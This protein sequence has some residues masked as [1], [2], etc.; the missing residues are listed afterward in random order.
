MSA[1]LL[2]VLTFAIAALTAAFAAPASADVP[3]AP[4]NDN[5]A[6]AVTV[7]G[8]STTVAGTTAFATNEPGDPQILGS[9]RPMTVW[10]KWTAPTTGYTQFD[11][12]T[13]GAF[14]GVIGVFTDP[15]SGILN[16]AAE[17]DQGCSSGNM[18]LV[19]LWATSGTTYWIAVA[20]AA[21]GSGGDFG[22]RVAMQPTSSTTPNV[23]GK[24]I[25]GT[26]SSVDDGDWSGATPISYAYSWARCDINGSNCTTIDG[27]TTLNYTPVELD[28][29]HTL[30]LMIFAE[31]FVS[32]VLAQSNASEIVDGD[33]DADGDYD[34]LDNCVIAA[35]ADQ[36]DLDSDGLGDACDDD[37]DADGVADLVDAC[38]LINETGPDGCA[39]RAADPPA[40]PVIS[41]VLDSPSNLGRIELKPRQRKFELGKVKA[42]AISSVG[43]RSGAAAAAAYAAT[44][45]IVASVKNPRTGKRKTVVLA[46]SKFTLHVGETLSPEFTLAKKAGA[47]LAKGKR[48][49]AKAELRFRSLADGSV[50]E[51]TPRLA[52]GTVPTVKR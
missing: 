4:A 33:A 45:R 41:L 43:N 12:C 34:T 38:P 52:L 50:R 49:S 40:T 8:Y 18:S 51:L 26:A 24:P 16:S 31:N 27:A 46:T 11:T 47:L 9:V 1:R 36:A 35:N 14:D 29:G 39:P 7:S 3:P 22:L 20:H 30:R 15:G 28:R 23:I 5:F 19:K 10:Y 32:N 42:A 48:I 6:N 13:S 2:A 21:A 25:I 17:A 37:D 44:G